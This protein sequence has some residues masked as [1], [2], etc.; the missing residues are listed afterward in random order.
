M[1]GDKEHIVPDIQ[2]PSLFVLEIRCM[3]IYVKYVE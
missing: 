1:E 2:S 3:R